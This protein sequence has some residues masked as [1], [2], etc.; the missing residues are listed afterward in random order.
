MTKPL[1][2]I[3][4]FEV[5]KADHIKGSW[6]L[7]GKI[8]YRVTNSHLVSGRVRLSY[9]MYGSTKTDYEPIREFKD[10]GELSFKFGPINTNT[11]TPQRIYQPGVGKLPGTWTTIYTSSGKSH[12]G[13]LVIFVECI[14][15]EGEGFGAASG[16]LLISNTKAILI[17]V[18]RK[19]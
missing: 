1:I 19:E 4:Q 8:R 16:D 7:A 17:N 15:P 14:T 3:E 2:Q 10:V 5:E 18:V 6:R 12:F 11:L 13:P 9:P